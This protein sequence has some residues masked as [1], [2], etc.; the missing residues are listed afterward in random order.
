VS[1]NKVS[2]CFDLRGAFH[3]LHSWLASTVSSFLHI[4]LSYLLH[5]QGDRSTLPT[6]CVMKLPA[7]LPGRQHCSSMAASFE[8]PHSWC[9]F[10][11][12]KDWGDAFPSLQHISVMGEIPHLLPGLCSFFLVCSG[13]TMFSPMAERERSICGFMQIKAAPVACLQRAAL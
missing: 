7:M 11:R 9:S 10:P 6:V 8:R 5:P 12:C 1:F 13:G 2:N 3:L 4:V